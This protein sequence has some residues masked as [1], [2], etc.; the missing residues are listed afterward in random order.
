[1]GK[2]ISLKL[3]VDEMDCQIENYFTVVNKQT[4]EFFS[5]SGDILRLVEEDEI[6]LENHPDWEQ[7]MIRQGIDILENEMN[8]VQIPSRFDINEY[9]IMEEFSLNI[10]PQKISNTLSRAIE[11]RGAFRRFKDKILELEID[12]EWYKFKKNRLKKI[13]K[14]WCQ[15]NG[16]DYSE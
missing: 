2:P 10:E 6:I 5:I 13:A 11:G 9:D 7:D 4:G 1:M 14:K 3:L 8:Y 12:E 16:I 15:M